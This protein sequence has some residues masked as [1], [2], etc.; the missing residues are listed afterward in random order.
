MNRV[1]IIEALRGRPYNAHQLAE[2][3]HLDYRT[4]R[5]HLE[6]LQKNGLITRPA[7]DA[8]ASP[9]FLSTYLEANLGVFDEIRS[10]AS[11]KAE[12]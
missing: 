3:L 7:G 10:K 8:Y 9:Y 11:P 5:H 4:V 12:D 2:T 6:L 1:R